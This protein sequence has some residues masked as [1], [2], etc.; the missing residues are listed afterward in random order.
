MSAPLEPAAPTKLDETRTALHAALV[1][2]MAACG[3]PAE[4]AHPL[5]PRQIV[6]P[7]GW[8]D[9]PTLSQGNVGGAAAVLVTF[10]V[11]ISLDG[12]DQE[13]VKQLDKLMAHGWAA[14]ETKLPSGHVPRI[15]TAGPQFLD[16]G[17]IETRAVVFSVQVTLQVRTLCSASVTASDE[18]PPVTP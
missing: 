18:A 17:G 3:W 2:T 1:A 13:Q 4:R 12:A 15:L 6:P 9:A 5:P 16:V 14:L 7:M 8:V 11:A 10:P